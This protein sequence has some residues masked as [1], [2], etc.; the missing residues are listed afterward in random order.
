MNKY[1][2]LLL[3]FVVV[4]IIHF[5]FQMAIDSLCN[6]FETVTSYLKTSLIFAVIYTPI[7]CFLEKKIKLPKIDQK[8]PFVAIDEEGNKGDSQ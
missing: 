8:R 3:L 5:L 6:E 7:T 4:F 1:T 2:K